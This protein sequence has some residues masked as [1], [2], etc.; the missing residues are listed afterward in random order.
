MDKEQIKKKV[1]EQ[2]RE[3]IKETMSKGKGSEKETKTDGE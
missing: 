3:K 1:K 2:V